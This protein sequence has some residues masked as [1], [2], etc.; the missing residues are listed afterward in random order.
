MSRVGGKKWMSVPRRK[1]TDET[2]R[3][4]SLGNTKQVDLEEVHRQRAA[5]M[6]MDDIAALQ[7]CTARTLQNKLR[8][9]REAK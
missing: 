4:I 3:L 5:G 2:R 1:V 7:N 8:R 9:E 6:R